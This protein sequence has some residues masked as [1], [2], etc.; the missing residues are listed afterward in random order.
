MLL[1]H[2]SYEKKNKKEDLSRKE[3]K[4]MFTMHFELFTLGKI[5]KIRFHSK[6]LTCVS[7]SSSHLD[8]IQ[9]CLSNILIMSKYVIHVC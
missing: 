9:I 6:F 5:Y 1:K 8:F 7:I 3:S 2:F 4:L